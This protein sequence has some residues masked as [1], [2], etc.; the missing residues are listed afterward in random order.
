M[1]IHRV[2]RGEDL[3]AIAKK[4]SQNVAKIWSDNDLFGD[5]LA[6]GEELLVLMPT[7]CETVRAKDTLESIGKRFGV[8]REALLMA[9]P[10]L[11]GH[12][13]LRPGQLLTIKHDTSRLGIASSLA[14][15]KRGCNRDKLRRAIAYAT[16]ISV[17]SMR[18]EEGKLVRD[19]DARW[20]E[21][22]CSSENKIYLLGVSDNTLGAFLG[23]KE[24]RDSVIDSLINAA[25][26]GG[27]HGV[28]LEA[29][30]AS[31]NS[32]DAFC[33]FILEARK[34]FIGCDLLFFTEIFEGTPKD[35]SE[36]SDGAILHIEGTGIDETR[37]AM[38]SF[39]SSAESSKV[40][41]NL[42]S[43]LPLLRGSISIREAKELCYRS[44]L[45]LETDE[46]T[47]LSSFNY[48]RYK[49]GEP[50]HQEIKFPSLRYTKAQLEELCELGF[51]GISFNADT[52]SASTLAMFASLFARADY[53]MPDRRSGR[54]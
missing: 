49:V 23:D 34:R 17:N 14:F 20:A 16:Y 10:G 53:S 7:R 12:D 46:K 8:R 6:V 27:Y 35:A 38:R 15:V 43:E 21:E 51:I 41:I 52:E 18:I 2:K 9:N 36:L 54:I 47:L 50:M 30:F 37:D 1:I 25:S 31:K 22:M 24:R 28:L 44:G 45:E 4:Y 33:E 29:R 19:F 42:S 48:T 26:K 40:F 3:Y 13:R 39:A 5:R 32:G 11:M